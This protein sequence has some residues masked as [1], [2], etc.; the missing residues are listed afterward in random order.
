MEP[1]IITLPGWMA[2]AFIVWSFLFFIQF[3]TELYG[4]MLRRKLKDHY[5]E[6]GEEFTRQVEK[7]IA[8]RKKANQSLDEDA[9]K[10]GHPSA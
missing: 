4:K 9:Q 6:I 1:I 3:I 5:A 2:F 7:T 8:L 10:A